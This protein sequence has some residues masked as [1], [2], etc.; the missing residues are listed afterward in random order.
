MHKLSVAVETQARARKMGCNLILAFFPAKLA[1]SLKHIQ[2]LKQ[3]SPQC[4]VTSRCLIFAM[5]QAAG[6]QEWGKKPFLD[7]WAPAPGSFG[8][9]LAGPKCTQDQPQRAFLAVWNIKV[10]KCCKYCYLQILR[11]NPQNWIMCVGIP[12]SLGARA[13]GSLG[14]D[15]LQIAN[16]SDEFLQFCLNTWS[17]TE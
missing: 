5:R 3:E 11:H 10:N 17:P 12:G 7:P 1:G 16:W 4:Q 15:W 13:L 8:Q 9:K 14:S 6:V 2:L